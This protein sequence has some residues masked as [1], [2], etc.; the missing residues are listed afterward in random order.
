MGWGGREEGGSGWGTHVHLW[1]IHVNV[2]QKPSQYCKVI[3]L[4]LKQINFLK[5]SE[6]T[7]TIVEIK[8]LIT[9]LYINLDTIKERI[10]G[11]KD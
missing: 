7:N 4:Q 2:W 5:I 6:M 10:V 9:G 11:L 1:L 3:I 8:K